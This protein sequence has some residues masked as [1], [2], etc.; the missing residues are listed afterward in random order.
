MLKR[1]TLLTIVLFSIQCHSQIKTIE[2]KKSYQKAIIQ[3]YVY[4][5]AQNYN[6]NYDMKEWQSCLDAGI[7][8]DSTIAYLWQQK[9]MPYFKIKKYEVGMEY[10]DKAVKYDANRYL[11]YRGFMKCIFSKSYQEAIRDFK[12][13]IEKWGDHYVMDHTYSFYIG[14]SYLQLNEFEKAEIYFGNTITEQEEESEEAHY[15]DLFYY[16]ITKY[17]LEKYEEAIKYFDKALEQYPQF[18]DVIYYKMLSVRRLGK[19]V[20]EYQYLLMQAKEFAEKGYTINEDNVVYEPYP[21][22]VKWK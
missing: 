16:G 22:Q 10:L 17:E 1:V 9:A 6:Y 2:E 7:K 11:P 20:D 14:L 13:S 4:E 19:P 12:E 8:K 18:S 5:C 3:E 15:L 21:Y